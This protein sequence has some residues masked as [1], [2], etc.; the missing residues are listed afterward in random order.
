MLRQIA[1]IT[2]CLMPASLWA[3]EGHGHIETASI[4][5]WL[6]EFEHSGWLL[7]GLVVLFVFLRRKKG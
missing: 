7:P 6:L 4:W 5:H 1:F 3:H 2:A